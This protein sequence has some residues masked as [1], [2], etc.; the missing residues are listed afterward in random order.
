MTKYI[1][2]TGGVCSSLGKG[3][4]AASIAMLLKRSGFS[5]VPMKLDPYLNVDPGTMN[6]QQHGEVF[7]TEDGCETDLDL[8]HYERFIDTPL[9]QRSTVTMGKI[10]EE[11]LQN[12]R[13]GHYLGKT[14]QVIPHITNAIK[15]KIYNTGKELNADVVIV[16]VGGTIGDI[17]GQPC[18][19]AIRQIQH[20][21]GKGRSAMIMLTLLPYLNS[22]KELKTKPTQIAV[23]EL[24]RIGIFPDMIL[25]RSDYPIPDELF[26]KISLFC[27]VE[28]ESIIPAYTLETIYEVPLRLAHSGIHTI[29][30]KQLGLN[31]TPRPDLQDFELLVDSIKNPDLEP[32]K[33]GMIAKYHELD[34][35]YISVNEAIKAACYAAH[36]RPQ[37]VSINAEKLEEEGSDE[38][39]KVQSLDAMIVPGGFGS[40]GIEGKIK[41]ATYA[42]TNKLPYLGICLGAQLM[43]IEFAR[44]VCGLAQANSTEFDPK[45]QHPVVDLM[46]TQIGVAK[47]GGTMRLGSYPCHLKEGTLAHTCYGNTGITERHRHRYEF[48]NTYKTQLEEKGLIVSGSY[49]EENI[50]EM[51]E[52]KDHPYMIGTQ[53]HPE[54][55]SRPGKPHP[56]FLGLIKAA[57]S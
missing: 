27:S 36:R 51:V 49:L 6:P 55:L 39:E 28:K 18:L 33:I 4:A 29:L 9:S 37:I 10:F 25:A 34:D 44:N 13:A 16:E 12:E 43:T 19:E 26:D 15:E 11:V 22:S 5:V 3:I 50:M 20:E 46:V 42:R 35:A 57:I 32:L 54:F 41:A 53:A 2:V 17:E 52:L 48:N 7:V 31:G 38:W 47:K 24:Q 30:M 23:R 14:I 1:F 8:G 21:V 40:R 56:L 45:T